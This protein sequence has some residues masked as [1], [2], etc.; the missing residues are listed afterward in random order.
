[1]RTRHALRLLGASGLLLA[2]SAVVPATSA[3][4][5]HIWKEDGLHKCDTSISCAVMAATL[6][7]SA[8]PKD[9]GGGV[10]SC[11]AGSVRPVGPL[12]PSDIVMEP[13]VVKP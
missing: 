12:G 6:C 9:E 11:P 10:K 3:A 8:K 7:G 5:D 4:R 1:M 2:G 13:I